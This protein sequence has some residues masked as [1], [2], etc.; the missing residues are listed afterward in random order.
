MIQ[1]RFYE[2]LNDFL[3]EALRKKTFSRPLTRRTSI[4]DVIESFGVPHP[5]VEIILV[6]GVSVD[7]SY[8]VQDSDRISVYPMFESIDVFPLVK[9]REDTLRRPGFVA[10]SNLGRLARYLRLL[11]MDCLYSN[12]YDDGTIARIAS[13]ERRTV[14]T[15]DRQLL[16]RK[17]ITHGYFVRN[18]DPQKQL[19]AVLARF[20]L[21]R[22]V[23]PF[24]R[25][26]RC[27]GELGI[28]EKNL[29]LDQLEP[30]TKK[31]Y[32]HFLRC[33]NCGQIY[34]KGSHHQQASAFISDILNN[35]LI[36]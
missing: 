21:R 3:P 25:C 36:P 23:K 4:K 24:S 17:L 26:T 32:E 14:L 30:K 11:G 6:N 10:D 16:Q 8:I 28:T 22:Q 34:W 27:N 5:E 1:L 33:D 2:E 31:Y 18:T 15:R 20:D 19:V 12:S 29:I 35:P 13:E 9:L 7:F